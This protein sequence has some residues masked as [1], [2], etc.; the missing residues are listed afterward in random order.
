MYELLKRAC[1]SINWLGNI[2]Y[3]WNLVGIESKDIET[4][5]VHIIN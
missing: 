5:E 4:W 3:L 1:S 2:E